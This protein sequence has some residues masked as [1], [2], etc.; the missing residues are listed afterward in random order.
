MASS[1][2]KTCVSSNVFGKQ[3]EGDAHSMSTFERSSMF[4]T[5]V[6]LDRCAVQNAVPSHSPASCPTKS[7]AYNMFLV[8]T[9]LEIDDVAVDKGGS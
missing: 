5:S 8:K 7:D 2:V 1:A 9:I 6:V 4:V 3:V